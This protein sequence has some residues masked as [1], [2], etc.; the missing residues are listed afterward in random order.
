VMHPVQS[1]NALDLVRRF[2]GRRVLLIGDAILD[3]YLEGEAARL[4]R[5]GP[6][7]VVRKT[8]EQRLPGGAANVAANLSALGAQV[9]FLSVVGA[10]IAASLLRQTLR[11][12]GVE[13]EWLVSDQTFQT[14]HKLRI[15][16]DGQHIARFDEGDVFAGTYAPEAQQR[17]LASLEMLYD[18]CE[19]V[20]LSDYRY[21]VLSPLLIERLQELLRANPKVAL[22]DAQTLTRWQRFPATVVTPNY[23]EA[24]LFIETMQ[25]QL[26]VASGVAGPANLVHVEAMAGHLRA[27]LAAEHIAITLAEHGMLVL[28]RDG[29]VKHFPA[30]PVAVAHDVGAGDSFL[31]TLTLALAAGGSIE[32]AVPIG[33]DAAGIAVSKPRTAVVSLQELLQ[34]VSVRLYAGLT[35]PL[36][37]HHPQIALARLAA[38][39]AEERL[40]GRTVVFTNGVFDIL[41]VGH[42]HFLRQA[43]SLGDFLV[44]GVNSDASARRLKGPGRPINNEHD[45]LALVA[46]LDMVDAAL[47]FEEDT[48]IELIRTLRPHVYVK[49]NDHSGE[50]LPEADM[51]REVGGRVVMLPLVGS[52]STSAVIE[53]IKS[54]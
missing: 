42:M 17:L 14:P 49:G 43:R 21:E 4:S 32:E 15:V 30:H 50:T 2:H 38:K 37:E 8:T 12:R 34:R 11:E 45:R 52:V 47:I 13:D 22:V 20:V 23:Q 6:I 46:A 26:P 3:S 44:V 16:A 35:H 25:G 1:P 40:A 48:A 36:E 39:L 41:H 5:D 18:R 7:P 24:A 53:R 31:S 19:A 27:S 29:H 9:S 51:V 10:D 28:D 54:D 33:I